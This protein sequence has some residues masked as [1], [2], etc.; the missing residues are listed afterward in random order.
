LSDTTLFVY[1]TL[2]RG[3]ANHH[4]LAGQTFL[5]E[6]VTLPRYRLVDF[7][8]NPGLLE[9]G[10]GTAVHG[11]LWR[12]DAP[13]LARLDAFEEI[14]HYFDRRPIAIRDFDGVEAY[15]FQGDPARGRECGDRWPPGM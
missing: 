4:F 8:P 7:G 3:L 13:T 9:A 11:E 10:P 15:F 12:V 6:A 1:G 2:K 14:P 5:G